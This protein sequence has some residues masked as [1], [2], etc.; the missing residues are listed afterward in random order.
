MKQ[1]L[2]WSLQFLHRNSKPTIAR[3]IISGIIVFILSDFFFHFGLFVLFF[4]WFEFYSHNLFYSVS[5]ILVSYTSVIKSQGER[6]M[7]ASY[8][9]KAIVSS[10]N[11]TMIVACKHAWRTCTLTIHFTVADHWFECKRTN[12]IEEYNDDIA[13]ASCL[14]QTFLHII[15][16]V[17]TA[18]AVIISAIGEAKWG[19]Q[20]IILKWK[21][22]VS[23]NKLSQ[24]VLQNI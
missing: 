3:F 9:I 10:Q 1:I 17:C 21:L 20:F 16:P 18:T 12:A 7:T 14:G 15:I 24:I 8:E 4:S 22:W 13:N 6:M 23:S 5:I 11:L 19:V 2:D